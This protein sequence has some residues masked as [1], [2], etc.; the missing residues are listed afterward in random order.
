MPHR[1][2]HP[3]GRRSGG[4]LPVDPGPRRRRCRGRRRQERDLGREGRSRHPAL[5]PGM[6]AMQ[7]VPVGQ[8]QPLHRDP[9]HAGPGRH[10]RRDQPVLARRREAVPLHGHVHL[11]QLQRHAGD[12]GRQGPRGRPV[13]QDLLH[14]LRRDHGNRRGDQ[15]RGRR[16]GRKRRCLRTRRYRPQ[17]HPGRADRR[18]RQDRRRRHQRVESHARREI[19]H[20]PF[21]Q[22]D[23]GRGRPRPLSGGPHRRRRGL[24]LRVHRQRVHD[25]PGARMLPSRLGGERD[26]RRRRRGAGDLDPPVPAG[27]RKGVEGH[28]LRRRQEPHRSAEDRR[29]VHGREDQYRRFDHPHHAA[30]GHQLGLRPDARRQVDPLGGHVLRALPRA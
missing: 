7:V 6:P 18:R 20:D 13:R 1:R 4:S 22:P 9:G 27:H 30:R 11:R 26:H 25:A 12:R 10:A 19:R 2:V 21:R 29:L 24:F 28:R 3:L 17:C 14:R 23:R 16:A 5:Y 8:D 15:H